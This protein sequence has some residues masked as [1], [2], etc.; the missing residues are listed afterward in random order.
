MVLGGGLLAQPAQG[1]AW[2]PKKEEECTMDG[3]Q[4]LEKVIFRLGEKGRAWSDKECLYR[5]HV[6]RMQNGGQ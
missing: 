5:H 3:A 1:L 6:G 4:I 2:V